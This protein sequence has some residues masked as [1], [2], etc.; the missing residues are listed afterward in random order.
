MVQ[1]TTKALH[2][3]VPVPEVGKIQQP[4]T[5]FLAFLLQVRPAKRF[6][7]MV[8]RDVLL[9]LAATLAEAGREMLAKA[10][11]TM[12]VVLAVVKAVV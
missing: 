8:R 4:Q 7:M 11:T 2:W 3:V 1:K 9:I 12:D 6:P 5:Q 10:E